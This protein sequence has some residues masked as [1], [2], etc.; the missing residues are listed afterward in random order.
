MEL[1]FEKQAF[2]FLHLETFSQGLCFFISLPV[3]LLLPIII[4]LSTHCYNHT[5]DLVFINSCATLQSHLK[6]CFSIPLLS[7][8]LTPSCFSTPTI[9]WWPSRPNILFT[10]PHL[11]SLMTLFP[12][13]SA[14]IPWSVCNHSLPYTCS[15]LPSSCFLTL[16]WLNHNPG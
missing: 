4:G 16:A 8:Q 13:Y 3:I 7:F 1:G 11:T 12:P 6:P 5:L 9:F 2:C 10:V 14:Y 15:P